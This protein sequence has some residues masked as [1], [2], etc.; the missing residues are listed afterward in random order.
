MMGL[1]EWMNPELFDLQLSYE[2]AFEFFEG[3]IPQYFEDDAPLS[4][5]LSGVFTYAPGDA[6]CGSSACEQA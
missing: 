6:S 2:E 5:M 3:Y 4:I 1:G